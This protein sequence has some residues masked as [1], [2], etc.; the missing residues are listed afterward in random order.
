MDAFVRRVVEMQ[1]KQNSNENKAWKQKRKYSEGHC[2][3]KNTASNNQT[4][5]AAAIISVF[6][7][8]VLSKAG[9]TKRSFQSS[10]LLSGQ[11]TTDVNQ[12]G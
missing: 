3:V 8:H 1:Q 4:E 5:S 2:R 9:E 6:D 7:I 10:L 11:Q 12:A